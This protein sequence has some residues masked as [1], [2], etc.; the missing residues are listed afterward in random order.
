MITDL[1]NHRHH[2]KCLAYCS[3]KAYVYRPFVPYGLLL[4]GAMFYST[5]LLIPELGQN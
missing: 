4:S 5:D 2:K 1:P 3:L